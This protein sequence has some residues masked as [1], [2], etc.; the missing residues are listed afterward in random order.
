LTSK[1]ATVAARSSFESDVRRHCESDFSRYRK[2][3]ATSGP[4]RDIR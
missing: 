2:A 4:I 3:V 1:A